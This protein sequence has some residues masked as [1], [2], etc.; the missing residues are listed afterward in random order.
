[1]KSSKC[2]DGLGRQYTRIAPRKSCTSFNKLRRDALS[3]AN[4]ACNRATSACEFC[5]DCDIC[6]PQTRTLSGNCSK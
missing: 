5:N 3:M 6:C 1:M 4:L 2:I